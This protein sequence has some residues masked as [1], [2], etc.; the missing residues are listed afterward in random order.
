MP[1][2][3]LPLLLR[4]LSS[5]ALAILTAAVPVR[6]DASEVVLVLGEEGG[7]YKEVAEE[8]RSRLEPVAKVSL[9]NTAG[10]KELERAQPRFVVAVGARAASMLASS[11]AGAP[12][13][14]TLLPKDAFER[15]VAGSR[16]EGVS[17]SMSAVY[18][19]HPLARQFDLIRLAMPEAQRIGVLLGPEARLR[20]GEL[21][22]A[23]LGNR[24]KLSTQLVAQDGDL[25][26]A[27]QKLLPEIDLLLALP[28][29]AV[30]NAGTIQMVLLSAYRH[31]RPLVGFSAAYTRAGAVLSL[32][33]TPRQIGRQAADMLRFAL[34]A[35]RLPAPQY[36]RNDEVSTNPH[37]A[38]SLGLSLESEERLLQRLRDLERD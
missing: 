9:H 25:A 12:V 18:L 5:Y 35:G 14:V 22:S 16:R 6:A 13:L 21:Q 31:Q 19:D 28:D 36:P 32:Y 15:L 26:P 7:A 4:T 23:A 27:L 34:S 33:S 24:L 29:P 2:L 8:I 20:F 11:P 37:V 10:L 3:P 1:R 30:L 38:R 17:R